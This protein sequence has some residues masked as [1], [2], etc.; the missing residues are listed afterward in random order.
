MLHIKMPAQPNKQIN[1]N[2]YCKKKKIQEFFTKSL[3]HYHLMSL[4]KNSK[5]QAAPLTDLIRISRDWTL[6]QHQCFL[7]F[8]RHSQAQTNA[9]RVEKYCIPKYW[10][11]AIKNPNLAT[12][13]HFKVFLLFSCSVV[14]DSLGPHGL[15]HIR[16]PCPSLSP[17]VC[18]NSWLMRQWCHPTISYWR[19]DWQTTSAF[20]PW[21]PH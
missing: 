17:G 19:R 21:E 7:K 2:E 16:F 1:K 11:R 20:L 8:P 12:L 13:N 14:S 6:P 3:L 4:F 18:S 5:V 10:E 15:Q 9:V